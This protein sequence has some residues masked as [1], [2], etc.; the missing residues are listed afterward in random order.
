M[1][2][3][4][5]KIIGFQSVVTEMKRLLLFS[6]PSKWP[7]T[8]RRRPLH[9]IRTLPTGL[10]VSVTWSEEDDVPIAA[11]IHFVPLRLARLVLA[12]VDYA[13]TSSAVA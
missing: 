1:G 10:L 3:R 8:H 9:G 5:R 7:T 12:I 6:N 13:T 4:A 11:L 2:A